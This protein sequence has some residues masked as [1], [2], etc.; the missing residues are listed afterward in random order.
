[1]T[2]A[3]R[4]LIRHPAVTPH[5]AAN[6]TAPRIVEAFAD[7]LPRFLIHDRQRAFPPGVPPLQIIVR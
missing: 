3:C 4:R 1:M 6:W 2:A 7:E 5:P